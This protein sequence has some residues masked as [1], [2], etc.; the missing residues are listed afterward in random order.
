MDLASAQKTLDILSNRGILVDIERDGQSWYVLPPP[1]AGFFEFSLM[2]I[3]DDIYQK[4][5]SELF[6][7]YLNVEERCLGCGLC[8]RSCTKGTISMKLRTVR[9]LT[10]VNGIHRSVIMAIERGNL[11]DLIFDNRVLLSHR[12]LAAVLGVI[13][14]LPPVKQAFAGRFLQSRYLENLVKMYKVSISSPVLA[15]Q[16]NLDD[17]C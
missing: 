10:P 3:R 17:A 9:M 2:R 7:Q 5:L 6:Y 16:M 14:K 15:G 1:R 12:A 4:I 13:L 8:A 11:Q